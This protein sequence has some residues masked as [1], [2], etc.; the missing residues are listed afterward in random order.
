MPSS[1]LELILYYNWDILE[2]YLVVSLVKVGNCE[3]ETL[4]GIIQR[5]MQ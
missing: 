2:Y 3:M 5:T 1:V 4:Q